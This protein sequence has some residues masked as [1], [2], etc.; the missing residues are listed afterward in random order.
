V[1]PART[2]WTYAGLG[3]VG[4]SDDGTGVSSGGAGIESLVANRKG[5]AIVD[6]VVVVGVVSNCRAAGWPPDEQLT[7][8]TA[9]AR[10]P[11]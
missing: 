5:S 7:R 1:V 2:Y 4:S 10:R 3:A 6:D 9:A 11:S 8:L